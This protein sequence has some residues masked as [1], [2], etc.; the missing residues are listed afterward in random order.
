MCAARDTPELSDLHLKEPEEVISLRFL[1]VAFD[2]LNVAIVSD[3]M[4]LMTADVRIFQC[5]ESEFKLELVFRL[6]IRL[7]LFG[8]RSVYP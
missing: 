2:F 3:N 1:F 7:S 4:R 5:S 8:T 6:R